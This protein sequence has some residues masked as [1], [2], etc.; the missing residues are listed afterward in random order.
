MTSKTKFTN[1]K[2]IIAGLT[3]LTTATM[4][5]VSQTNA[6]KQL[7][8][9]DGASEK[10]KG[11]NV[12]VEHKELDKTVSDAKKSGMEVTQ[13]KT[14]V[15]VIKASE[16]STESSKIKAE[17]TKQKQVIDDNLKKQKSQ[18]D[19]YNKALDE[20]NKELA[21]Y[22]KTAALIPN[23]D[24]S[25]KTSLNATGGVSSIDGW[26]FMMTGAR[27]KVHESEAIVV[28]DGISESEA[29]KHYLKDNTQLAWG[30]N[31]KLV[32]KTGETTDFNGGY[33]FT[34]GGSVKL[35]NVGTLADGTN[36]N[37]IYKNVSG[38]TNSWSIAPRDTGIDD[39]KPSGKIIIGSQDDIKLEYAFVDDQGNPLKIWVGNFF[40]DIDEPVA[41][42]VQNEDLT[43]VQTNGI[44]VVAKNLDINKYNLVRNDGQRDNHDSNLNSVM[45]MTYSEGGTLRVWNSGTTKSTGYDVHSLRMI[46]PM[47]GEQLNLKVSV[48][49]VAPPKPE[50]LKATYTLTSLIV[51]PEPK[52][53]VDAGNNDGDK[54]GKDNNKE[55]IKGQELTYSLKSTDLPAD[56]TDDVKTFKYVDALPKQVDY[57]S[58]KVLSVDGKTDLT[59]QFDIQYDKG[60]HT[61]TV[62]AKADYLKLM[63]AD[64]TKAFVKPIV[65]VH[66]VANQDNTTIDNK[67]TEWVND[68]SNDS[69]TTHNVTPD[70]KPTKDVDTGTNEGNKDGSDNDKKIVKGQALTYSLEVS[71]LPANRAYDLETFKFVD[72][73][74]KEVDYKSAKVFTAKDKDGKVTDISKQFEISYDKTTHTVTVTAN[75]DYLKS[76]NAD[77]TKEFATPTVDIYTVANKDNSTIDNQYTVFENDSSYDSNKTH[78]V[79]PDVKPEKKDEDDKGND[80]NGKDVKPGQEM[81]YDLTWDLSG[82]KDVSLSDDMIVKGLSFSDDYDETKLDITDKTKSDFSITDTTTKKSVLDEVDVKW[83]IDKG[84]WIVSA[85]DAKA[86]LKS[87]AGN[88]LQIMFN[89]V[90]KEDATGTLTNTAVQ[91]DFGQNYDT[92]TVKNPVTPDP[93]PT[94]TPDN[95]LPHTGEQKALWSFAGFAM[96]IVAFAITKRKKIKAYL[97]KNKK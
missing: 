23:R 22:N 86:F 8:H 27:D 85:K 82:L 44:A 10:E 14:N 51:T 31:S 1:K 6:V 34:S 56:R 46:S 74:P 88:K 63:N 61:V 79:T 84:Q 62:S 65:N 29:K 36:V 43:N 57:K 12:D 70:V 54:G 3:V 69:N 52:K 39:D 81:N 21:E 76:M 19:T 45:S 90:V 77:K 50:P 37:L 75:A 87:H 48:K 97:G 2:M 72:K 71:K 25:N 93:K 92:E 68:D 16:L 95:I 94:P 17:Y 5:G 30:A 33:I 66:T 28:A 4:L 20:Y 60:K 38:D 58:V 83:D 91:N 64:K 24:D 35:T 55:I 89:P 53:D 59:K 7:V 13:G 42:Y 11:T 9:A 49:P 26:K 15:K 96:L 67:Y 78:N 47:F 73:L 80:I 41:N 18:N 40:S 32:E